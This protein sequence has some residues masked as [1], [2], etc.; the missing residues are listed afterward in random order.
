MAKF[1]HMY[2]SGKLKNKKGVNVPGVSVNLP[3]IT[4]KDA[5]RYRI[6]Y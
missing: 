4:E 5:Q 1:I 3:G 6:W 2:N